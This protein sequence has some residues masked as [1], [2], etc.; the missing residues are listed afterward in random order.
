VA[1]IVRREFLQLIG[2][3]AGLPF[4]TAALAE[5]YP[6][7]P[8]RLVVYFPA[9]T[10]NDIIGRLIS[11]RLSERM[12]QPVVVDNHPG[13]AGNLGTELV[14]H[15][16]PDGYTLLLAGAPN[17]VNTT[18][19]DNLSFNFIRDI[20]PVACIGKGPFV[21]VV[22]PDVPA[23]SIAEFINYAKSNPD[24]IN[25]VTG[26][27]GTSTHV[28]GELFM[29]KTGVKL[30]HVPYRS[31]YMADLV[32]GQ[33][34]IVFGPIPSLI[35]YIRN[36][37]LRALAVTTAARSPALP[38]IPAVGETVPDYDAISW[39]GIG[40]PKDTPA[41]VVQTLNAQVNAV[42]GEADIKAKLLN[43][44]V[45]SAPMTSAEFGKFVLSETNKWA[46]VI[47]YAGIRP[48]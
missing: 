24:K 16:A 26:G 44:G 27:K 47:K 42:L 21:V 25:M 10:A 40:A 35:S 20:V 2:G 1:K 48:D 18:L 5:N 29:M 4:A 22:N 38:D 3:A 6:E 45:D 41:A 34:Q 28:F 9:G 33:V 8:V 11:Q 7:R 46:E 19:Y 36:G 17:A 37:K 12:G 15:A 32:A 23:H 30:V 13:A 43:L 31:D 14:A 39:Y